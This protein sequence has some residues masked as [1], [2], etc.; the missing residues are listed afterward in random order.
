MFFESL[1]S[2][3]SPG[4][5]VKWWGAIGLL[6][7]GTAW[8]TGCAMQAQARLRYR[9]TVEV[10][11][12]EGMKSGSSVIESIITKGP[13][14][15][16]SS[17]ISYAVKGE[18]VIVDL[19]G[20]Q[21]LFALL[22]GLDREPRFFQAHLFHNALERGAVATPPLPRKYTAQEWREE[23]AAAMSGKPLVV[24]QPEDYPKLV[25]F[26]D[27]ADP[28]TIEAVD[29][30]SLSTAFGQGVALKKVSIEVTDD[31][32]EPRIKHVLVWLGD[33]PEPSLNPGHSPTDRTLSATTHH[34]DF[35]RGTAK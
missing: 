6:A 20:G 4:R 7:A 8:L 15:G 35:I 13:R 22:S 26:R 2:A 24:L 1:D 23:R 30:L 19:G 28:R 33:Y 21:M 5:A 3:A 18:A 34:G 14:F 9:M 32:P 16:D 11:T 27:L 29:P 12:P 25:R 17:G 10:E 31:E